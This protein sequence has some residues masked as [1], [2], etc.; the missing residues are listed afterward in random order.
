MDERSAA[1]MAC[2]IAEE[3]GEPVVITC[4]GATASR[5]YFSGLTEAYYRHLPILAITYTQPVCNVGHNVPQVIDRSV[6]SNDIAKKSIYVPMVKDSL[7]EWLCNINV[8]D[9]ILEVTHNQPGPV[10]F[11]VE[12]VQEEL[13]MSK[14]LLR[15]GQLIEFCLSRRF[16]KSKER[17]PFL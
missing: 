1:Y 14:R 4:T 5:N 9:G 17:W 8:N 6:I 12:T 13:S 3:S 11:N 10:H 15:L 2:G 7:D 16:Q